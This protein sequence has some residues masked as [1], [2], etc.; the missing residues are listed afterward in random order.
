[1][2]EDLLSRWVKFYQSLLSGPSPEVAVIASVAAADV[3]S[4]TGANNKLILDTT[5]LDPKVATSL[6][7]RDELR[8]RERVMT[9]QEQA[10]AWELGQLLEDRAR[11]EYEDQDVQL[12][13]ER[14]NHLCVN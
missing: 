7:V 9:E 1:L 5:G 4:T 6:Q 2:K 8:R 11:M 3:R 14:I 12:I 13:T 10:V